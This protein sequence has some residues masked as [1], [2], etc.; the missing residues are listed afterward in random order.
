MHEERCLMPTLAFWMDE[1]V[2]RHGFVYKGFL[3]RPGLGALS[4]NVTVNEV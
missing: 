4:S 2:Y 1:R 3:W